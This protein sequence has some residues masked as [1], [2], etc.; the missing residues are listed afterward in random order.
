MV[1]WPIK[2]DTEN[3]FPAQKLKGKYC[4]SP[5]IQVSIGRTGLVGICGCNRWQPT[6]IGNIFDHTLTELLAGYA[7]QE[8]R[9]SII[10]GTFIYCHPERCGILRTNQLNDYET[11]PTDVK[12]A[13]EDSS[14]FLTPRHIVLAMDATCN[15]SCPSCRQNII[16]NS[17]DDREKQKQMS[18]ILKNNIFGIPTE[19]P[20]ELTLD[21][22]GDIFASPLMLDFLNNISSQDF[23]N[24][25]L[26]I[27]SNG[28]MAEQRWHRM[29]DMQNHVKQI[30]IS[31]DAARADT[32]EQLR[33]GGRWTDLLQAMSWLKQKKKQNGMKFNA[34][35]VVQRANYKEMK[36]FYDLSKSFDCDDIQFQRLLNWGT[37]TDQEFEYLDVCDPKSDLYDNVLEHVA[38]V[39]DL[40]DALF[41]H[42]MPNI[43]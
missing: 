29:G 14:R 7:A 13:V 5:F 4:L 35:M 23:P 3:I 6:S 9:Q 32:Y 40:P 43:S 37:F 34:R 22:S 27:L 19:R 8:I 12:W 2:L 38:Q 31:Y 24:L 17:E 10:D 33:R 20:I 18:L 28:L 21:T 1:I 26:D 11:L 42:G 16:K 15:L 30:T 36:E 25:R 39:I 41:W